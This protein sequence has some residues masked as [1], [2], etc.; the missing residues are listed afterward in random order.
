MKYSELLQKINVLDI[1][2]KYHRIKKIHEVWPK[3]LS[4]HN[5]TE[6]FAL[7]LNITSVSQSVYL[8]F[9]LILINNG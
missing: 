2:T 3:S 6:S 5:F 4:V 9:Y 7:C 8:K 1:E